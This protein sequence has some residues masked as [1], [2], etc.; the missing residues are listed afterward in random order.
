MNDFL[1]NTSRRVSKTDA[2]KMSLCLRLR[3]HVGELYCT[4]MAYNGCMGGEIDDPSACPRRETRGMDEPSSSS[5]SRSFRSSIYTDASS[6]SS[7]FQASSSIKHSSHKMS[8][9]TPC[10]KLRQRFQFGNMS[11]NHGISVHRR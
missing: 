4:V 10:E 3:N 9:E 7:R 1:M 2:L 5:Y 11:L 6:L 8:A